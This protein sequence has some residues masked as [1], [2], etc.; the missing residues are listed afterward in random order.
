MTVSLVLLGWAAWNAA[1]GPG[2][3]LVPDSRGGSADTLPS[4]H[5]E[6]GSTD[7]R[8][9]EVDGISFS[10]TK[11]VLLPQVAVREEK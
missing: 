6:M 5:L 4:T 7:E 11:S 1:R 2:S 10:N 9:K 8:G 3:A